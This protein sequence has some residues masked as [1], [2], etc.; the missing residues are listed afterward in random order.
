LLA[1]FRN[2]GYSFLIMSR[3]ISW[4]QRHRGL[5]LAPRASSRFTNGGCPE[6]G[7]RRPK[8]FFARR[9]AQPIEK[10]RFGEGNP[11]KSKEIQ[12]FS[13]DFLGSDLAG[14]GQIWLDLG[15]FGSDGR[16][17]ASM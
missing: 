15:K 7:G 12:T 11:R 9:S 14:F 3:S 6:A 13:L 17:P 5:R 10:A 8:S 1:K 4:L 2:E 16:N